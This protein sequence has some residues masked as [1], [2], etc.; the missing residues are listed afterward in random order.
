MRFPGTQAPP[1]HARGMLVR[2]VRVLDPWVLGMRV[3]GMRVLTVRV[4]R[5]RAPGGRWVPG[6]RLRRS[7]V[8]LLIAA[9]S[10]LAVAAGSPPA[11]GASPSGATPP[12]LAML[13]PPQ[14]GLPPR[15][16]PAG[17]SSPSAAPARRLLP[18]DVLV[19][20][21]DPLPAGAAAK[22]RGCPASARPSP[23]TPPG[24]G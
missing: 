2:G 13:V 4:L 24:C 16:A 20:S 17:G 12:A 6:H 18:A 8:P 9:S 19:V 10:L 14:P 22:L 11:G 7:G 1:W 3:L 23:W 15:V 5:R 21:D